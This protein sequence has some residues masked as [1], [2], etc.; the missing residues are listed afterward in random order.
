MQDPLMKLDCAVSEQFNPIKSA[1]ELLIA[2][3]VKLATAGARAKLNTIKVR[4]SI[5][6]YPQM[7]EPRLSILK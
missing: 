6:A 4:L 1:V 7:T 3:D 5:I 2:W